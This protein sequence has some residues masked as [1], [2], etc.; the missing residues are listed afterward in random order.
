MRIEPS[1]ARSKSGALATTPR[2]LKTWMVGICPGGIWH[3]GLLSSGY[4]SGGI[5]PGGICPGGICPRTVQHIQAGQAHVKRRYKKS[6][7][8]YKENI[9]GDSNE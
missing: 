3:G 6:V 5:C 8:G 7:D 9:N 1:S 2:E 4:M